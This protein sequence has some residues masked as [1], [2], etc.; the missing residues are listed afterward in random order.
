M[1]HIPLDFSLSYTIFL[2][3][4]L[5]LVSLEMT[6][7][8]FPETHQ[9]PQVPETP[10]TQEQQ[11]YGLVGFINTNID[12]MKKSMTEVEQIEFDPQLVT[13]LGYFINLD[14]EFTALVELLLCDRINGIPPSVIKGRSFNS[15]SAEIMDTIRNLII[16]NID[17]CLKIAKL[18]DDRLTKIKPITNLS[19][20]RIALESPL[21][22]PKSNCYESDVKTITKE[23]KLNYLYS[24][25]KMLSFCIH[26]YFH[27]MFHLGCKEDHVRINISL[28]S[29]CILISSCLNGCGFNADTR[30][31]QYMFRIDDPKLKKNIKDLY[32]KIKWAFTLTW[33]QLWASI[34]S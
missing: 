14:L 4:F 13:E 21:L 11:Q 26:D 33:E 12:E 27:P 29:K 19:P 1:L 32:V 22:L 31:E 2:F 9:T 17:F 28:N 30:T 15:I 25:K 5:L 20:I 10:I 7:P 3:V 34:Y 24:S 8:E 6:N 18:V 23:D 16:C